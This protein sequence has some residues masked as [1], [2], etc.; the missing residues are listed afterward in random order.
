MFRQKCPHFNSEKD[1]D[2]I[3][4]LVSS[5]SLFSYYILHSNLQYTLASIVHSPRGVHYSEGHGYVIDKV[6][7]SPLAF[8]E[9]TSELISIL[10]SKCYTVQTK[11]RNTSRQWQRK[12]GSNSMLLVPARLL[13]VITEDE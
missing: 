1:T 7:R 8:R 3:Q 12:L 2:G 13:L 10:R 4:D 11:C 9:R 6:T 5:R